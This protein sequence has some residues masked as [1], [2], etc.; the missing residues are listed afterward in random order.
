MT[1][2]NHITDARIQTILLDTHKIRNFIT[3][4]KFN[5]LL[6]D[7]QHIKLLGLAPCSMIA[8]TS[9]GGVEQKCQP[10]QKRMEGFV[11]KAH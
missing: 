11:V 4:L 2:L 9:N 8:H 3:E 7:H 1:T 5:C 10:S 6:Y